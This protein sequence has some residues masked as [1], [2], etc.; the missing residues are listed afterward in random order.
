MSLSAIDLI[1]ICINTLVRIIPVGLYAGSAMSGVVFNDF[2]GMLL[3]GGFLANE[4]IGLGYRMVLRGVPNPQC[5]LLYSEGGS[6]F[7][8]PSPITQTVG[9]FAGFFFMDMYYNNVFNAG[10]FIILTL[11]LFIT[12]YSR[13]NVGCKTLL[14]AVYCALI[15]LLSGVIYYAIIKDYYKAD[16]WNTTL[17]KANEQVNSFFSIN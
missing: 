9:F 10:K 4:L 16:Y 1:K 13:I 14:D 11:L 5:A 15:G 17:T 12:M 8:L 6:P 7:V 2:R 3:F